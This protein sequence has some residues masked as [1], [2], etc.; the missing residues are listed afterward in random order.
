MAPTTRSTALTTAAA[1]ASKAGKAKSKAPKGKNDSR[2][3]AMASANRVRKATPPRNA[4]G[5][6]YVDDTSRIVS[7]DF[8]PEIP[9]SSQGHQRV[10]E[11]TPPPS[12]L[13]DAEDEISRLRQSSGIATA[14]TGYADTVVVGMKTRRLS[15][16]LRRLVIGRG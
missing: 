7:P 14:P 10:V 6:V 12:S 9:P 16:R 11:E 2:S 13:A 8:I 3:K 1:V 5:Y 4:R 15:Q